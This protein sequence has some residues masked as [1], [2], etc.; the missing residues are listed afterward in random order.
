[1]RDDIVIEVQTVNDRPFKGSLT[2]KE[3]MDGV[4]ATCLGLDKK[5]VHGVRFAFS[6]Y[7]VI[8]FKLKQQIDVDR[9]LQ[10]VEFF[11]YERRYTIKGVERR[12]ILNCKVRGL[13]TLTSTN[14]PEDTDPN[15]RWVK[16]E[17]L[18]YGLEETQI[19]DWLNHFGEQ[20]GELTEDIHPNS[21]SDAD[22]LGNGT[23]SIK[24]RLNR[25]IPQLLPMWGKRVRIYHRGIQKLCSNC[26]GSHAR[27]NCRSEKV[28]WTRYVL[29]FMEKFPEIPSELY[30]RWWKV[31]NDEFG[32]IIEDGEQETDPM[33]TEPNPN[34]Q[35]RE[36]AASSTGGPT[37]RNKA[38]PQDTNKT[39]L[40]KEEESNLAEY[41]SIGMSIEDAR[42]AFETEV[43]AAELRLRVRENQRARQRGSIQQANR[44]QWGPSTSNRGT[45]RG[46]LSFN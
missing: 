21:D 38:Q 19:L 14:N 7:P 35:P 39:R 15:I 23:F 34:T 16:L 26:F 30:G 37:Q 13:R 25:D 20:A 17:W 18:D 12:D 9:E 45:G 44:T 27:R 24:M 32:E 2:L 33:E 6:T 8:K 1:M 31:I 41:L 4:F 28:A 36:P 11:E 29:N 22:P 5:L 40:T 10:H 3:A 42:E 46:G 43:K